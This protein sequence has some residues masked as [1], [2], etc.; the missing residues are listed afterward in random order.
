[1][2]VLRGASAEPAGPPF[3]SPTELSLNAKSEAFQLK[4]SD[5]ERARRR[6]AV[7]SPILM[8][9]RWR[10]G[11]LATEAG[12]GKNSVYDYLNGRRAKI[13][14]GNRK[15]IAQALDLSPHQLPD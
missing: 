10:P 12:V 8:R 11:R 13:T 14:E 2:R 7:V 3:E 1:M 4:E 5:V 9:K 6:Q 15:A